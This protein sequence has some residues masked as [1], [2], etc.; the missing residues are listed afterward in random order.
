[1]FLYLT[2]EDLIFQDGCI[3]SAKK[4]REC[5]SDARDRTGG[6]GQKDGD[7]YEQIKEEN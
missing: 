6:S 4:A 3:F 7:G 1:M 2:R 5:I